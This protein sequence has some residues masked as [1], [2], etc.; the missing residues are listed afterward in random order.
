MKVLLVSTSD[1]LGGAAIGA[2]RLHRALRGQGVDSQMLVLRKVTADPHVH[3]LADY[4]GRMGRG[5]RRL[6]EYRHHRRLRGAP[7][8]AEAGHWSLNLYA[9]GIADVINAFAPDIVHLQWIGDNSLPI[10]Q[11]A[12][13]SAPLVWTLQDMWALTGGCHYTGDCQ[14]YHGACGRC[15]QLLAGTEQDLSRQVMLAKQ[16]HWAGQA[17]SVVCLSR[18]LADCARQ[19]ALMRGCRIE[20]IGNPL[21]P[22]VFKPIDSLAARRV[23]N[24][25]LDKKLILFGA[26]G[27]TSDRRKGFAYLHEA[28][29]G[30]NA[31]GR[32][33]AGHLWRPKPG[34]AR[35]APANSSGGRAAR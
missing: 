28:L 19:S 33:G 6:A 10:S 21:D 23:F 20:V 14:R 27:G 13:I 4:L 30:M 26:T 31:G 22:H 16:R 5:R 1:R 32:R 3:R 24:L 17:M 35:A 7:R 25:P 2:Y 11:I 8:T 9:Y 15:P 34:R 18:W 12:G 29:L